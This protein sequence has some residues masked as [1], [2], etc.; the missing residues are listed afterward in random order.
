M[1]ERAVQGSGDYEYTVYTTWELSLRMIENMQDEM[2]RD[3]FELL[4]IFSF[5]HYNGISE[6]IFHRGW[7]AWRGFDP[8][9]TLPKAFLRYR[10]ARLL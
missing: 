5:L 8:E 10:P 7:Q 6:E 3:V 2:G 4:Q 9:G 1:T